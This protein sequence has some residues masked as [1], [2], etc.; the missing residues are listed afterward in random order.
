VPPFEEHELITYPLRQ[1][2]RGAIQAALSGFAGTIVAAIQRSLAG[3][4]F[5]PARGTKAFPPV[6]SAV[7]AESDALA[8]QE[9]AESAMHT[10]I[11]KCAQG[12]RSYLAFVPRVRSPQPSPLL[13]MLHG[14]AQSAADFARGTR[15]HDS[16]AAQGYVVV[17]PNQSSLGNPNACWNWYRATDQQRDR[18]EPAIL[19]ALAA[20]M[21]RRFNCDPRRVYV[22]G[23]SAG[24]TMAITLGKVYPEVF[25]AVGAHSGVPHACAH[26]VPSAYGA[27][28]RGAKR[29]PRGAADTAPNAAVPTIVFHGD[30]DR[31]VNVRNASEVVDD[32][33]GE[34]QED[35]AAIASG[36]SPGTSI[37]GS[38]KDGHAFTTTRIRDAAGKPQVESWIV[39]GGGH[40]WFGGSADG[41]CTDAK[42]PNA[43]AEMLRFFGSIA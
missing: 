13:L 1:S 31:T 24:G 3:F 8:V 40:A 30:L 2:M 28:R 32:A 20:E 10:G 39:H 37:S 19:A 14:C 41:S 35:S 5:A 16:A 36:K 21:T 11:F 22:A 27:M 23:L 7:A 34:R 18:G 29:R 25:R 9:P 6:T 42:G 12:S 15:M 4:C 43:S 33:R 26:D 38:V 17:Y